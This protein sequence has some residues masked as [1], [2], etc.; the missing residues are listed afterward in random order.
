MC[1]ILGL[2]FSAYKYYAQF[3]SGC[4]S[5]TVVAAPAPQSATHLLQTTFSECS[6]GTYRSVNTHLFMYAPFKVQSTSATFNVQS[7]SAPIRY[8]QF[9]PTSA[10]FSLW[11]HF[12]AVS[13]H[14]RRRLSLSPWSMSKGIPKWISKWQTTSINRK[15]A[16]QIQVQ[17]CQNTLWLLLLYK[18]HWRTCHHLK[19]CLNSVQVSR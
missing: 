8:N 7:I 12:C 4:N 6:A 1:F 16:N 3:S 13:L 17:H 2:Y 15:L 11:L 9:L 18:H 19:C 14:I 10:L 5:L